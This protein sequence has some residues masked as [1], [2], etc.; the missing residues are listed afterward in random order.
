[1]NK[2]PDFRAIEFRSRSEIRNW[3]EANHATASTFWLVSY[4][5]HVKEHY[6]PY[7]EIVDELLC[8][9]WIDSRTRRV[10]E[11]R[12][13][14]LVAP[15][16]PGS[17][18]SASN[19]Q[20][21]ARLVSQ[22]LLTPAGQA[23][24][25]AAKRDGSWSYLDDIENL[26]IPDDLASALKKNKAAQRNFESFNAS[27]KKVILLWIKTAKREPT[28]LKRVKETVRLAAR[29]LKAAHPESRGE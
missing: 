19:K 25:D 14:L 3:L 15:R 16:K 22:G 4:K 23:R 26:V 8:F 12:T 17:T 9:G 29:G 20:R 11:N 24:I 28:R 1:M 7:G 5:K 6:V 13:M 21:V 27:A 18:W 10:D 2:S